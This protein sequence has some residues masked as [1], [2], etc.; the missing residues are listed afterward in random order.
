VALVVGAREILGEDSVGAAAAAVVAA[1][2]AE[3]EVAVEV[4]GGL[5][6]M[7]MSMS[8]GSWGLV[9]LQVAWRAMMLM[10]MVM[11]LW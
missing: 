5:M 7:L 6:V 11:Q 3:V 10:V 8:S 1:V 2:A 9:G 4:A